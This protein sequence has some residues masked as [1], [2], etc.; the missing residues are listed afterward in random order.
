MRVGGHWELP[1]GAGCSGSVAQE[2][3]GPL[4]IPAGNQ[5]HGMRVLPLQWELQPSSR[6]GLKLRVLLPFQRSGGGCA[7]PQLPDTTGQHG[8]VWEERGWQFLTMIT[9][10]GMVT[11]AMRLWV[12]VSA[13]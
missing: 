6:A 9:V 13:L 4:P 2:P 3:T 5:S 12:M 10:Q 1:R 8:P 11:P 7:G